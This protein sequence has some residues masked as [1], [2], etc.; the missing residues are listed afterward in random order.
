[1]LQSIYNSLNRGYS[2]IQRF[3]R[4]RDLNHSLEPSDRPV[5]L[6][7]SRLEQRMVLSASALGVVDAVAAE[8]I[9]AGSLDAG[10]SV[11]SASLEVDLFSQSGEGNHNLNG[12]SS[13]GPI[14]FGGIAPVAPSAGTAQG[15][16]LTSGLAATTGSL[17]YGSGL[18]QPNVETFAEFGDGLHSAV[19]NQ[20]LGTFFI[21][22]W[23]SHH[24]GND[25]NSSLFHSSGLSASLKS[26]FDSIKDTVSIN[27]DDGIVTIEF[28]DYGEIV[29]DKNE[30]TLSFDFDLGDCQFA[31][32][33]DS[34]KFDGTISGTIAIVG[35]SHD[36]L[37]LVGSGQIGEETFDVIACKQ[38]VSGTI[39]FCGYTMEIYRYDSYAITE[40]SADASA[41]EAAE[42]PNTPNSTTP[43][44]D[45]SGPL[46]SAP[47]TF[48]PFDAYQY[49]YGPQEFFHH[50][51]PQNLAEEVTSSTVDWMHD[52]VQF[53]EHAHWLAVGPIDC[54]WDAA[55]VG[56]TVGQGPSDVA[57]PAQGSTETSA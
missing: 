34:E 51:S 41:V 33:C 53:L 15:A 32:Y 35:D 55:P 12:D 26:H 43:T 10:T 9:D 8:L 52:Q 44:G 38:D 23:D 3:A 6:F 48:E 22:V 20:D 40:T 39:D 54:G 46:S 29:L 19:H 21:D 45:P 2:R 18:S 57:P 17:W 28:D 25:S 37:A 1:M 7:V 4:K 16:G 11:E 14:S 50:I 31:E 24:G 47:Q 27:H 13:F 30:Y 5:R 49:G 36:S 56:S 42:S